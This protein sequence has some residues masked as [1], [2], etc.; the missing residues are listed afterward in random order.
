[1]SIAPV[2]HAVVVSVPPARAFAAFTGNIGRWWPKGRTA[3]ATPHAAIVIEPR[4]GGR[5]FERDAEGRET[6]W[7]VVLEWAPP[8]RLLLGWQLNA[9]FSHDPECTTEVE[10]RFTP[11]GA[12]TL[13]S[14]EHRD[15]HRFGTDAAVVAEK[16]N[17]G[18]PTM[19][20]HL[21]DFVIKGEQVS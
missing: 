5:W 16:L 11:E 3:A 19:L 8:H 18:W 20:G 15:L 2:R 13:V 14:L 12:G 1:M 10:V 9:R 21:A 7:G 6:D 17:S 4:A